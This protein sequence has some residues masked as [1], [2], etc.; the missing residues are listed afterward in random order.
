MPLPGTPHAAKVGVLWQYGAAASQ[1]ENTFY[2]QDATDNLFSDP[3]GFLDQVDAAVA[4]HLINEWFPVVT[5]HGLTFEDV[6]SVPFGGME[7]P[8]GPTPGT[9]AGGSGS[10]PAD[11]AAAVKKTTGALGR[12]GRG[13]WYWPVGDKAWLATDSSLT[14][15]A[16]AEMVAALAAFQ[17]AVEGGTYPCEMGIVSYYSGKVLR[18]SGVFYQI[19]G[20]GLTD[21]IVDSQ[22]RR[23]P[24]RGR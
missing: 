6:R 14:A 20:W 22:R 16:Q 18:P 8:Y 10:L 2:V 21:P 24:G 5:Y 23:L 7:K 11:V 12:S 9:H 17:A 19:T 3:D 13:R 1:C 4:A 15:A